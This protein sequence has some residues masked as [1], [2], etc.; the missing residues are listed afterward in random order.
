[1]SDR[2]IVALLMGARIKS[3]KSNVVEEIYVWQVKVEL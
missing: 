3:E 1:M 2:D